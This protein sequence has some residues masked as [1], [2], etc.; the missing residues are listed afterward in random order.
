MD[1]KRVVAQFDLLTRIEDEI[2]ATTERLYWLR[3]AVSR[4]ETMAAFDRAAQAAPKPKLRA[5]KTRRTA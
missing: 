1:A 4:M 2:A 3:L 5:V